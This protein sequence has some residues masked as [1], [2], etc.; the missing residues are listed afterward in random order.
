MQTVV[1]TCEKDQFPISDLKQF[2]LNTGA[3]VLIKKYAEI[4]NGEIKY[5][6]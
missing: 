4:K 1:F 6:N 2:S 3:I 5:F